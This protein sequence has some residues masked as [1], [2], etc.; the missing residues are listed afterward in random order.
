[1]DDTWN[2]HNRQRR[3]VGREL[4]SRSICVNLSSEPR[5]WGRP[6]DGPL[7]PKLT[8][9]L[10]GGLDMGHKITA[11]ILDIAPAIALGLGDSFPVFDV[12]LALAEDVKSSRVRRLS[13]NS[14]RD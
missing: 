13:R 12:D 1:M 14:V 2:G 11:V 9:M 6:G 10:Q 5:L 8:L 4:A 3:D 7:S